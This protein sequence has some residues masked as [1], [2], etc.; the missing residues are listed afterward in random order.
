MSYSFDGNNDSLTGTF[1]TARA[2]PL[3][4][5]CWIKF[6]DHPE[7]LRRIMC[8]GASPSSN[9]SAIE[10]RL[11]PTDNQFSAVSV[12][13]SGGVANAN[14]VKTGVDA[15]WIPIICVFTSTTSRDIYVADLTTN[16]TASNDPGSSLANIKFG[17]GLGGANDFLGRVA[18]GAI[19]DKALDSGERAAYLAGNAASVIAAANLIGYWPMSSAGLTNQGTDATG[20]LTAN[21]NAAFD[22]DHPTIITAPGG[23]FRSRIAGGHVLGRGSGR[24]A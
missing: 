14:R 22:A 1:T 17:E 10:F 23:G 11:T 16:N 13:A 15:T 20:N 21:N 24:I 12:A 6:A 8:L 5:A 19:W 4:L 7:A 18:E 9:N 3:T 2:L